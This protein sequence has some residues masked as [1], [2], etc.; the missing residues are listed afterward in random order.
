[1]QSYETTFLFL[2]KL[3]LS[4]TNVFLL[5]LEKLLPFRLMFSDY[6]LQGEDAL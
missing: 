6:V 2:Y 4:A 5:C 1:M 3:T